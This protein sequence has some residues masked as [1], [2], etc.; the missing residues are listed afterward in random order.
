MNAL[1]LV[2]GYGTRLRPLTLT[3]PKPLV[4]FCNKAILEHQILNLAKSGVNEIILAI[5]YKPDNIKSFV[6]NLQQKYNVKIFFS[7]ENEPLGTGGPIKL[8]ENFL[9]KYDDFFV[10]N[11]DI[12]CSFPLIDMMKFHKENKSL[13]TIMVKDVDDPRSFGVVITDNEKKILKFEEKPLIPESSLINSGIY[14]LNKK[15]LNFIPKRN[16]S[17][18]KEIFP[19]LATDNLLYF[20]KLN[21]F[22]AD[23]GKPSDF[24][25]GQSLYLNSFQNLD[26]LKNDKE[27]TIIPDQ[28]LI[29]YNIN[30]DENKDI[31][32]NKLFISFENIEEL[33]KFDENT[34]QVLNNIKNFYIK[35]EGNVLISSNTVIKNNC[36]LGENVVLGNNVILGEGCRIKNSC[37]LRD[38]VINSYSYIDNS[39]IGSKSCIGSWARIEG[40]CV[41]GENV[42]LKPELFINNVFILPYKEVTNSIYDKGA[43]I[44]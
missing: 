27:K 43:I 25:K 13:L 35:I 39:I 17:L 30:E 42:N 33:N 44:M 24:L 5:A 34:N 9:S 1:L 21:G 4:D 11:S 38:S 31:K 10:F 32:K 3:T 16:T 29:C 2:G 12:I 40:L 36:F 22:W 37:I 14:I 8:A 6:N 41:L 26:K 19:N 7:I 15:I 23:I 18:E 20:Y 28:L